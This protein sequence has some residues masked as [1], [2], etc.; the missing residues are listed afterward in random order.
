VR[1]SQRRSGPQSSACS[2]FTSRSST[3][4]AA[5]RSPA[6]KRTSRSRKSDDD[7][8][9]STD[10]SL[11]GL[12]AE[13]L[14][15]GVLSNAGKPPQWVTL[16]VGAYFST[17]IDPCSPYTQRLRKTAYNLAELGWN[18]KAIEALGGETKPE[19]IR[20]IGFTINEWLAVNAK[21]YYPAFVQEMLEGEGKLDETIQNVLNGNREQFLAA[22]GE[23]VAMH[24]EIRR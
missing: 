20:A 15:I 7:E 10:R 5:R 4:S 1:W 17:T 13:N 9:P 2:S 22:T 19:D 11:A 18:A 24:Y 23:W 21:D 8:G 3:R 16:G 6:P 12:L 14:A